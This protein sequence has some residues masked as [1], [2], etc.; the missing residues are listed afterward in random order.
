MKIIPQSILLKFLKCTEPWNVNLEETLEITQ[1]YSPLFYK[2][3]NWSSAKITCRKSR[4]HL[5][6]TWPQTPG[7]PIPTLVLAPTRCPQHQSLVRSSFRNA[8]HAKLD[9]DSTLRPVS[10]AWNCDSRSPAGSS[11]TN[12]GS[13][14]CS[15]FRSSLQLQSSTSIHT[16]I[17][18]WSGMEIDASGFLLCPR[19]VNSLNLLKHSAVALHPQ[20]RSNLG[21][22]FSF[23]F[24]AMPPSLSEM[25]KYKQWST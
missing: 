17:G 12:T 8:L 16:G 6:Q 20:K 7:L 4:I 25:S 3:E 23:Y 9:S 18:K 19:S 13:E 1:G 10:R 2:G 22:F 15:V 24:F 11:V 5:L 14:V 21:Y